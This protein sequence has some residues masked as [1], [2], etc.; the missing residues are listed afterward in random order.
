MKK[1]KYFNTFDFGSPRIERFYTVD[2]EV[3]LCAC[4]SRPSNHLIYDYVAETVIVSVRQIADDLGL[5]F[6]GVLKVIKSFEDAKII[7]SLTPKERY[8]TYGYVPVLDLVEYSE[9]FS[10]EK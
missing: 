2:I 5:S 10:S 8:R 3:H 1:W 4:V 9:L 6:S 7:Q